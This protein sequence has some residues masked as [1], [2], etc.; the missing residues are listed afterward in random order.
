MPTRFLLVLLAFTACAPTTPAVT[1]I[2]ATAS[3]A[4]TAS[5]TASPAPPTASPSPEPAKAPPAPRTA[6]MRAKEAT[7]PAV[8]GSRRTVSSTAYCLR[9]TMADGTQVRDGSVAMNGVPFGSRWRVL[10]G[11]VAG[12]EYFVRDRIGHSSQFDIWM[13]GC[14]AAL[15]YGRRTIGIERV[16]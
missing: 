2:T 4:P 16:G 8:T 11:P 15:Q 12:R 10:S 1:K 7:V 14:G 5:P 3:P 6:Q 13:S 9:G